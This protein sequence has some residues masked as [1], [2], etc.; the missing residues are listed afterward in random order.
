MALP[1]IQL[2]RTENRIQIEP[3]YQCPQQHHS[4]WP[5]AGNNPS[6]P[7]N[8]STQCGI[9]YSAIRRNGILTHAI[10][11]MNLENIM[12]DNISQTQ[13]GKEYDSTYTTNKQIH[14]HR[15]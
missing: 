3:V 11:R 1:G 13:K 8:K 5:K 2:Q 15:K 12:L 14:R 7:M 4:Q 10:T 6:V 9:Y